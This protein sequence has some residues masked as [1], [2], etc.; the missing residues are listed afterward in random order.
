MERYMRTQE[1]LNRFDIS[2]QTLYRWIKNKDISDPQ[3]DWRN[4][5]IWS[6]KNI[7][8]IPIINTILF[9]F[10]LLHS[11]IIYIFIY[12]I[13][14]YNVIHIIITDEKKESYKELHTQ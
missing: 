8:E 2:R 13:K 11:S 7:I 3:R 6:E 4:W 1:I 10:I 14:K 12:A 5:R 9:T